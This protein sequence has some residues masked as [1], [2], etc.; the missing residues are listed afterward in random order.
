M[1]EESLKTKEKA[2]GLSNISADV[3]YHQEAYDF[4]KSILPSDYEDKL[5]EFAKSRNYNVNEFMLF[6]KFIEDDISF[7]S[8]MVRL[9]YY[10]C[11]SIKKDESI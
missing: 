2:E 5:M 4:L 10:V 3:N 8:N 9:K 7:Y 6:S 11:N 1:K